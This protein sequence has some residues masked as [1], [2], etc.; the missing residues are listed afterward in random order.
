MNSVRDLEQRIERER[1]A[2][3]DRDVLRDSAV[4]KQRFPH[5]NTYPSRQRLAERLRACLGNLSHK[6]ILDYGCGRGNDSL[7]YLEGGA[8]K[9][10]GIDISDAYIQGAQDNA[11]RGGFSQDRFSFQVMD[12]HALLFEA[13][14]F[15]LV[16]GTGVLHHLHPEIAL[17]EIWRVLKSGGRALFFEPLAD[18]PLLR[19]FRFLTPQERTKD[20]RPIDRKLLAWMAWNVRWN[21]QFDYCGLVEAPVAVLTSLILRDSPDNKLLRIVDRLEVSVRQRRLLSSW[22]QYVLINLEKRGE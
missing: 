20:E 8:S 22:N 3:T 4:L 1:Q 2:H 18:N 6:V 19:L 9:V 11:N 13:N 12:A 17:D 15:D 16:V 7:T 5:I 21:A 10:Y 14:T